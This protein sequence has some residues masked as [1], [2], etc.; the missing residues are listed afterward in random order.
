MGGALINWKLVAG[1][2]VLG[3]LV[4]LIFGIAGGNPFGTILVRLVVSAVLLGA[5]GGAAG[6]LVRKFMPEL[7]A[8]SAGSAEGGS[9]SAPRQGG[10]AEAPEVDIVIDEELPLGAE[11]LLA[12]APVEQ[13]AAEAAP[14]G[15]EPGPSASEEA[16]AAGPP[17][18]L[19]EELAPLEEAAGPV[20]EQAAEQAALTGSD[21]E[22]E[23]LDA[24]PALEEPAPG[25]E[26]AEGLDR[27][28]ETSPASI[29]RTQRE[30]EQARVA[31][32]DP[33]ELAKAVRTFMKKDQEG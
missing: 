3:A 21:D 10:G 17:S 4:S 23:L 13:E 33:A 15:G 31:A 19:L 22:T 29:R 5:L 7:E 8:G 14:V 1:L 25:A 28:A 12:R 20:A 32:Q 11:G 18:E 27:A 30:Q 16:Q 6:L 2:A 9:A 26:G 24:L